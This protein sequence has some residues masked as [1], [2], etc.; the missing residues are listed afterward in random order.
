[1]TDIAYAVRRLD[2]QLRPWMGLDP[3]EPGRSSLFQAELPATLRDLLRELRA[4]DADQIV[5]ELGYDEANL[6][7]D[8][9]PRAQAKLRHQGVR[10]ACNTRFG[11]AQFATAEFWNWKDNLRGIALGM[12]ALRAVDRYGITKRGEQ[13]V[14]FRAIPQR[15]GT[16]ATQEDARRFLDEHGGFR[17][18]ARRFHPD[19]PETGDEG[20]FKQLVAAKELIEA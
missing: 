19:N 20:V 6:R 17:A 14:G 15:T 10:L 9:L 8:G 5:L 7:L 1:M 13:Y 11:P 18:G 16:F 3:T 12:E 4:I 2:A